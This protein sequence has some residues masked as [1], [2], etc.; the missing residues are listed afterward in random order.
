MNIVFFGT[1]QFA[2]PTLQALLAHPDFQV[3]AVVTQ[4]DKKRGRGNQ[5]IPSDI[6]KIALEHDLTIFT[7]KSVKK[8]RETLE[9]LKNLD[10]DVFVVVAYGQILSPEILA[11]PKFGC[12]NVH[13]SI[14]PK[15][16]GAAP[17]Q[18][19]LYHGEAETGITTMLMDEGLDTGDML[20]KSFTPINLLDNAEDL[21]LKL[22]QQGADLLIE[23]LLKLDTIKPTP[24]DDSQSNYAPLI[25]KTDFELNWSNSALQIHNQIRAFY[26][27]C[28]TK[29]RDQDL[30]ILAT[31]PLGEEYLTQ[32]PPEF[33]ILKQRSPELTSLTGQPGEIVFNLKKF[34]PIIQTGNGLLLLSQI[35]LAGKKPQSGWDFVNGKRLNLGEFFG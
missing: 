10:A 9:T 16:R 32:L 11:M 31:I 35:Q 29:F 5:M 21:A 13:G 17:I 12:I 22:A 28:V 20:L 14:L 25:K 2:T 23:T 33:N 7:P 4:P 6:K 18:W 30:K 34:G 24:Q 15:Y 26:P 3:L 8:H 19:S 1:P 27:H